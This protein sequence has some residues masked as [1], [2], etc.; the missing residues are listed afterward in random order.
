M[1][2]KTPF[3]KI[4]IADLPNNPENFYLKAQEFFNSIFGN[5]LQIEVTNEKIVQGLI[6]FIGEQKLADNVIVHVSVLDVSLMDAPSI[7]LAEAIYTNPTSF[8]IEFSIPLDARKFNPWGRY[9][10]SVVIKEKGQLRYISDTQTD[11]TDD[12]GK[13]KNIIFEIFKKILNLFSKI[14][15]L[16][17][18]NILEYP[19]LVTVI[20]VARPI[21]PNSELTLVPVPTPF[22][23]TRKDTIKG[24]LVCSSAK[25]NGTQKDKQTLTISIKDVSLA[26]APSKTIA[27]K[28]ISLAGNWTF[29]ISYEIEFD[30]TKVYENLWRTFAISAVMTNPSN[31][32]LNF[33][34][35][36]RHEITNRFASQPTILKNI[37]INIVVV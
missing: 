32:K 28:E 2:K 26:D 16:I 31:D 20:D 11:V 9:T 34:S 14:F 37:D 5:V 29:P 10:L 21:P 13:L 15:L 7:K 18:G 3:L 12:N 35:D 30:S 24:F 1:E 22:T 19:L 23:L 6:H 33:I 4:D 27:R 25:C 17:K 36:T 8:P